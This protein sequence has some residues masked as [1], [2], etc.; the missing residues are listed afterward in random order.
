V[1]LKLIMVSK[2]PESG[3]VTVVCRFRPF[4]QTELA[5]GAKCVVQFLDHQSVKFT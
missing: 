3:N 1:E 4:N 2:S 5:M